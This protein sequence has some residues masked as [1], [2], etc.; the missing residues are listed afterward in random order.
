MAE[1]CFI[2]EHLWLVK[3]DLD[4]NSCIIKSQV[5]ADSQQIR[6]IKDSLNSS[7]IDE[8]ENG[9]D[10]LAY[11]LKNCDLKYLEL[12]IVDWLRALLHNFINNNGSPFKLKA[13]S[14][15]VAALLFY[16]LNAIPTVKAQIKKDYTNSIFE[17]VLNLKS[18]RCSIA[19][20]IF[21]RTVLSVF[22]HSIGNLKMKMEK[23]TLNFLKNEKPQPEVVYE[24]AKTL[25]Y[26]LA[27]G[28]VSGSSGNP[29]NTFAKLYFR[30][31][32]RL[33][34]TCHKLLDF[35]IMDEYKGKEIEKELDAQPIL[36]GIPDMNGSSAKKPRR[37]EDDDELTPTK[38]AVYFE[39][40]IFT[41]RQLLTTPT[42]NQVEIPV[43]PIIELLNRIVNFCAFSKE[44][45][46]PHIDGNLTWNHIVYYATLV[47]ESLTKS[48]KETT[49]SRYKNFLD[50]YI[51]LLEETTN[52]RSKQNNGI[53]R[54]T[55]YAGLEALLKNCSAIQPHADNKTIVKILKFAIIDCKEDCRQGDASKPPVFNFER[56]ECSKVACLRV[57]ITYVLNYGKHI[58]GENFQSLLSFL[59]EKIFQVQMDL[60]KNN[61]NNSSFSYSVNYRWDQ[62]K[63]P[64]LNSN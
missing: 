27:M 64:I 17:T 40:M 21:L 29:E 18:T 62:L 30:M 39:I 57:L 12:N 44:E 6:N 42:K 59:F 3:D 26:V 28:S 63:N 55:A 60:K 13:K 14:L 2:K 54:K 35:L 45:L 53:I 32:C 8:Q 15:N 24:A 51:Y 61:F 38:A 43:T 1:K 52:Y 41:L 9:L 56:N 34:V 23:F 33:L 25:P 47:L 11:A 46:L 22:P 7:D 48:C 31:C 49:V 19:Q 16:Q 5:N 10:I 58:S 50:I 20:L 36:E 4:V 37:Y